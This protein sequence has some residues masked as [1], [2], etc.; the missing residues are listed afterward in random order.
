M[1]EFHDLEV[2]FLNE[3]NQSVLFVEGLDELIQIR[4]DLCIYRV[5][6]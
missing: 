5:E 2:K 1:D 4:S 6:N 3:S